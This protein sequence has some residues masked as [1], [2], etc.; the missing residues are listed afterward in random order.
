MTIKVT[1]KT[2]FFHPESTILSNK[3]LRKLLAEFK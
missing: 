1:L 3:K 2:V